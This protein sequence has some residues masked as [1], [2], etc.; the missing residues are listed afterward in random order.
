MKD[1]EGSPSG[2]RSRADQ[3]NVSIF[4]NA[5]LVLVGPAIRIKEGATLKEG[6]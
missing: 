2:V 6:I 1:E 5:S 4:L 3:N